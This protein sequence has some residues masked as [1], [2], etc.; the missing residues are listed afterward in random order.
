MSTPTM[1]ASTMA[2]RQS[3]GCNRYAAECDCRGESDECSIMHLI[4]Y[5]GLKPK[6]VAGTTTAS[7]CHEGL[8]AARTRLRVL[9]TVMRFTR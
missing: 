4:L 6:L 3:A 2:G 5:Y 9:K 1:S 7:G 8:Q